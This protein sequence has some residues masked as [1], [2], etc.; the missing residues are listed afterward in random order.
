[1]LNRN[2][3]ARFYVIARGW[4]SALTKGIHRSNLSCGRT[5]ERLPRRNFV[6]PRNDE[7]ALL[8]GAK[9][10]PRHNN[11]KFNSQFPITNFRFPFTFSL[12]NSLAFTLAEVLITLGIIGVVAGLMIPGVIAESQKAGY[13]AGARKAYS[14]WNQALIQMAADGGCIGDLSCFFDS[15]D[16]KT[17]GD[18]IVKYFNVA[19][20]CDT[21]TSGC[22]PN[23]VA[24]NFDGSDIHSGYDGTNNYYR[25]ITADGMAIEINVPYLGCSGSGG[26][27]TKICMYWVYI[28]VNGLKKPNAFG[29][30]IF[31][32][33]IVN[34]NGPALYPY[35]G[36]KYAPWK[37]NSGC[38]YGYNNGT[39]KQGKYCAGRIID[40][41]WQ[42]NY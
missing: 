10:L 6:S 26:S 31:R 41:G 9:H 42:M 38:N 24:N 25:F 14:L 19:K 32:F 28:D 11:G 39:D 8:H 1:M 36:A 30:D 35:G 21:T 3:I 5:L 17:M 15:A 27:L 12:S 18:K 4:L 33:A 13:V 40:E 34:D 2:T 23:T 7:N 16:L 22:F 20:N 37:I 29:R